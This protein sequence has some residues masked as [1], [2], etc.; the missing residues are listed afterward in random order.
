MYLSARIAAQNVTP[1]KYVLYC[2]N[3]FLFFVFLHVL[4]FFIIP[5]PFDEDR[6]VLHFSWEI[7][8]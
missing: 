5:L 4:F 3:I 2:I 8:S 7:E 6:R 1:L